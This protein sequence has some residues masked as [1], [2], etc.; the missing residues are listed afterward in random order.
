MNFR[1]R[2]RA[3]I[4]KREKENQRLAV[5]AM[6]DGKKS[7]VDSCGHTID[8]LPY[9]WHAPLKPSEPPKTGKKKAKK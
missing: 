8:L 1:E 4:R 2:E 9:D 7:F 6:C 3:E 5:E